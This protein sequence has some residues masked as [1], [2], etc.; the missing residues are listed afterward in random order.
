MVGAHRMGATFD[1]RLSTVDH[2]IRQGR[3]QCRQSA[4]MFGRRRGK[5]C[6]QPGEGIVPRMRW[7]RFVDT[8]FVPGQPGGNRRA[9]CVA[10]R[11]LTGK[12]CT[13]HRQAI[14]RQTKDQDDPQIRQ[15]VHADIEVHLA[16]GRHVRAA[17]LS[18]DGS[19]EAD[20]GAFAA[21]SVRTSVE[22]RRAREYRPSQFGVLDRHFRSRFER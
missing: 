3:T 11:Q 13:E 8:P 4:D 19:R 14:L 18:I 16:D 15:G 17:G 9:T 21:R 20:I 5:V 10:L 22:Q 7:Y 12:R 1:Q 2:R 6:T